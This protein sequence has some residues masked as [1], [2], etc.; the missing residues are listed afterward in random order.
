MH[1]DRHTG[2]KKKKEKQRGWGGGGG[3]DETKKKELTKINNEKIPSNQTNKIEL[4]DGSLN[5]STTYRAL[6][7]V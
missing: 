2:E 5:S 4:H 3:G 1:K 6:A 7:G